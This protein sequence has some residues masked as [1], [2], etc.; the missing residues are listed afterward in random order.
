[1][2]L[3]IGRR[4]RRTWL[5]VAALACAAAAPQ[6]SAQ[7]TARLCADGENELPGPACLVAHQAIGSLPDAPLYWTLFTFD[8]LATA[9]RSVSR[10]SSPA[11]SASIVRAFGQVWAFVVGPDPASLEHSVRVARIG[12]IPI[13]AGGGD[14]SAE[15][16]KSTFAP[17]M[18]APLHV[19]SGPEAFYAISGSTCL[20]TPDGVQVARGPGNSLIVRRG[21]PMLLAA[22]GDE[23]RQ[24]FAMI[25]HA[26]GEPPTT[27]THDWTPRGLC[28]KE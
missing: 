20:E 12:P 3:R 2:N 13:V 19:H 6:V 11:S 4:R 27:L 8:D 22:I 26:D 7:A 5:V 23:T 9:E 18:T 28:P 25:L 17:G 15:F 24:G 1:M 14:Y 16:L 10:A 21:P